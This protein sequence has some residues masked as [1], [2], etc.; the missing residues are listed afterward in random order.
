MTGSG[1]N[2]ISELPGASGIFFSTPSSSFVTPAEFA[3]PG[4]TRRPANNRQ[5]EQLQLGQ[6]GQNGQPF[7]V[8]QVETTHSPQPTTF[9]PVRPRQPGPSVPTFAPIRPR[10]PG[11]TNQPFAV[12]P[13]PS[14]QPF[15]NVGPSRQP[16][17]NVG[18]PSVRPFNDPVDPSFI[19]PQN[20]V[21][22]LNRQQNP[23]TTPQ[24]RTQGPVVQQSFGFGF[25]PRPNNGRGVP[26]GLTT[27]RTPR[28]QTP[29][30]TTR[31][32]R[33]PLPPR[34][35]TSRQRLAQSRNR[36]SRRGKQQRQQL[37]LGG[38]N[39]GAD[40][41]FVRRNM[42]MNI[43]LRP[44]GGEKAKALPRPKVEVS[45]EGSNVILVRLTFPENENIQ[46]LRAFT[47]TDP[48][49]L[50][51]FAQLRDS[52]ARDA[53]IERISAISSEESSEDDFIQDPRSRTIFDD[54]KR[55]L[56]PN[57]TR[58]TR[59][60]KVLPRESSANTFF[61]LHTEL[62]NR[63]DTSN[64]H[65]RPRE[66]EPF[67]AHEAV[68]PEGRAAQESY[69]P[70]GQ[71]YRPARPPRAPQGAP[72]PLKV[73]PPPGPPPRGGP[74]RRPA[75]PPRKLPAGGVQLTRT[76]RRHPRVIVQSRVDSLPAY[77]KLTSAWRERK[78]LK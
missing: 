75:R 30:P 29:A 74:P 26:T 18:G 40:D 47:P 11:P 68:K 72:G 48:K 13:G 37:A 32:P 51:K 60:S 55:S 14:L 78:P 70:Q 12:T 58:P 8:D 59:P 66:T 65:I 23:S 6:D 31:A 28:A 41:P 71:P 19:V 67:L 52:I 73:P 2:S 45:S 3:T 20:S 56:S 57:P 42:L 1:V 34:G 44:G 21:Q 25:S 43:I 24:P 46:G 10:Q 5:N 77:P 35:P 7:K 54:D 39:A 15:T 62:Q 16:F 22:P 38:D 53:S 63:Q 27:L 69:Y 76:G 9:A 64:S 17:N 4:P 61:H 36:G 33:P 50:E 49:D